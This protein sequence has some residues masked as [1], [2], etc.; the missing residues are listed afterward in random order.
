MTDERDSSGLRS[1][2]LTESR[3]LALANRLSR[4]LSEAP[5][6]SSSKELGEVRLT[7]DF[8]SP[9]VFSELSH[10]GG[11]PFILRGDG[12]SGQSV[13]ASILS[14]DFYPDIAVSFGS[15]HLWAAE[16][17]F[18]RSTNRN[19]AIAKSIGQGSLYRTRYQYVTVLLIDWSPGSELET[20]AA[21]EAAKKIGLDLLVRPFKAGEVRQG[22]TNGH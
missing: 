17:K 1:E 16:V 2:V 5:I 8:L 14:Q 12:G 11:A 21:V 9:A 15:D 10:Y 7:A 18:L 19:D 4:I 13:P 22:R 20:G 3:K 6:S